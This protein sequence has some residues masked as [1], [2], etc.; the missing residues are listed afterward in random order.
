MI[1]KVC[2][3]KEFGDFK[4]IEDRYN[5]YKNY[6]L[7][8]QPH[9]VYTL[10]STF[11]NGSNYKAYELIRGSKADKL[12]VNGAKISE[13]HANFIINFNNCCAKD[14]LELI[15][16]IIKKVYNI[17]IIKL[18]SEIE[19]FQSGGLQNEYKKS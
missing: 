14:I 10:G 2:L 16:N 7:N 13:K 4:S 1:S 19:I 9:L 18:E 5:E 8:N 3:K 12:M 17:N 11:K 15:E 6:R